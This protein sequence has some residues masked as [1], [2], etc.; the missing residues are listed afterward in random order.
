MSNTFRFFG[1]MDFIKIMTKPKMLNKNLHGAKINK[2]DEFYTQIDDIERELIHYTEHFKGK[3]V[4]SNCDTSDSNF[5]KYFKDNSA[6]LGLKRFIH[7]AHDFRS[8][9]CIEL[10]KEADIVVTNPPFSLFREYVAQLVKYKKKF[11]IIGNVNA[12][13]YKE[14]YPLIK[15]N[16]LWWGVSPRS[17]TFELP[18]GTKSQVNACWYTNLSHKKRNEEIILVK[19][20]KGHEDDYPKYDNYDAIEVSKV[21]NI[22]KDYD[23]VMGV[24]IT[25]MDKYNPDQFEIVWLACGHSK[26]T[27]PEHI[28][29]EVKFDP[30]IK[31][32]HNTGGYGIV[33]GE[34]KYHRILIRRR[35]KD[36]D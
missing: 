28:K 27:M 14:I 6:A 2:N 1:I 12:V 16:K 15:E 29:K 21:V 3:V 8:E 24:P 11:L 7:T 9:E 32:K 22:P 26:T 33:A 34:Q 19:R 23:G 10:L 35:Q 5:V 13:T 30:D 36:E 20:Y 18:D 4:Y 31:S 17:M 25:F